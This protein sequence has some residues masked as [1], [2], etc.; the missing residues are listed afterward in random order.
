MAVKD[1][2]AWG[3]KKRHQVTLPSG[4]EVEIEIPDLPAL[5]AAGTIPQDLLDTAIEL[6]DQDPASFKGR[7]GE[8][9]KEQRI[10]TNTLVRITVKSPDLTDSSDDEIET[11][12]PVP[13]REM[14]AEFALRQRDIDAN[15][16]HIGGLHKSASFR[17]A[18]GI[19]DPDEGF[20]GL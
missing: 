14:I 12:I 4:A 2:K 16:E 11:N 10:L 19:P 8:L 6:A 15:F 18:R 9:V 5:M 7:S 1:L 20:S 3:A 17:A 13:D